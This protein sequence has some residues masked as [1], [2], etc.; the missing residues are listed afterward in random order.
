MCH[1]VLEPVTVLL[2][3]LVRVVREIARTVCESVST[4]IRT[5]KTVV[6]RVCRRLPWPL[7]KLCSLVTKVIEVFETVTKWV[8]REVIDRIVSWIEHIVEYVI[9]VLRWVCWVVSLPGRFI[10][11]LLCR[12]GLLG[13]RRIHVCVRVLT[14]ERGAPAVSWEKVDRDLEQAKGLFEQCQIELIEIGRRRLVG[15]NFFDGITCGV[16]G[17]FSEFFTWFSRHECTE[18]SA[19]TVYYVNTIDGAGGCAYPGSNWVTVAASNDGGTIVHE[20]G[21][22]SDLWA[23]TSDPDNIMTN[24]PGGSQDRITAHQCCMMRTSRFARSEQCGPRLAL[25]PDRDVAG[26]APVPGM[27][28]PIERPSDVP[29]GGVMPTRLAQAGLAIATTA[30]LGWRFSRAVARR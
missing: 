9:F 10:R 21:H 29:A 5:V 7:N 20:I 13:P 6:E 18:C 2:R 25:L 24:Q 22:L 12:L 28:P 15:P 27:V 26:V 16:G 4:V 14:D 23:H 17:I 19:V 3:T 1:A 8:C 11:M 30:V